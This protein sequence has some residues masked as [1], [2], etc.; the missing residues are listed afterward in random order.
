MDGVPAR[1]YGLALNGGCAAIVTEKTQA[2][3][4]SVTGALSSIRA[5]DAGGN[6][7]LVSFTSSVAMPRN[8]ASL[9]GTDPRLTYLVSS[10]A[11]A[12]LDASSFAV[13]P[14]PAGVGRLFRTTDGGATWSAF[15]GNGT[16]LDLP[17]VGVYV[18]RYD[19]SDPTDQTIYAGTE[20]G[21]YR[22]TDGGQTWARFGVGLPLVRVTDVAISRS[23]A[24]VRAS[25]FGRGMWELQVKSE[26]S[27]VAGKGDFDANGVVDPF[28][29]MALAARMGVAP[30]GNPSSYST[31]FYD[32][33]LDLGGA[34]PALIQE[35]DLS[36]LLAKLGSTP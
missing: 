6:A 21:L 18:V 4:V 26:P 9:G 12:G 24:V 14:I 8:P 10:N 7:F 2:G 13:V 33:D 1:L 20:L 23:G 32:S 35:D 3:T 28:D 11:P 16:G 27:A 29:V 19:T 25:T 34:N 22:T 5:T 36:A 15:H 17:N 30:L 31:P